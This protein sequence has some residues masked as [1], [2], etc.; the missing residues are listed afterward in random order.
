MNDVASRA[1]AKRLLPDD[2]AGA[3]FTITNPGASGTWM[4]F[5]IINQPQVAILSTDGVARRVVAAERGVDI[6]LRGYLCL[7]YDER[8]IEPADAG[9]FL[10]HVATLIASRDWSAEI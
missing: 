8:V 9:A 1:R 4:S 10:D 7:A 2:L 6:G 5:P 3:T